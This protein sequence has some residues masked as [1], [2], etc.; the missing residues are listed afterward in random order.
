MCTGQQ[1]SVSVVFVGVGNLQG[2]GL[3]LWL[4]KDKQAVHLQ[5]LL[6]GQSREEVV[7]EIV[8]HSCC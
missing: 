7:Q 1:V 8:L 5:Q 3:L 4:L 2:C 6:P